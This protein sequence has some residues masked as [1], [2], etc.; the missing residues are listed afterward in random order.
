MSYPGGEKGGEEGR[1]GRSRQEI[2]IPVEEEEE[3]YFNQW[4]G[5]EEGEEGVEGRRGNGTTEEEGGTRRVGGALSEKRMQFE[6]DTLYFFCTEGERIFPFGEERR[7]E[8]GGERKIKVSVVIPSKFLN[9]SESGEEEWV[10][11]GKEGEQEG[12]LEGFVEL[13]SFVEEARVY[14]LSASPVLS[15]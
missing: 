3:N 7:E 8:D 10:V 1:G 14:P 15:Y 4:V 13:V 2:I 12:A 5:E 6:E 9:I 11:G